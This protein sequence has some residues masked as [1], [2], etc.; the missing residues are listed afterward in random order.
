MPFLT[1]AAYKAHKEYIANGEAPGFKINYTSKEEFLLENATNVHLSYI[2]AAAYQIFPEDNTDVCH[3]CLATPKHDKQNCP[4]SISFSAQG[5]KLPI[6]CQ[7][8]YCINSSD[9]NT[10]YCPYLNRRCQECL[11]RGHH[12]DQDLCAN[13]KENQQIFLA[14]CHQGWLTKKHSDPRSSAAGFFPILTIS[15]A[16]CF[17]NMGGTQQLHTLSQEEAMS[18]LATVEGIEKSYVACEPHITESVTR[19]CLDFHAKARERREREEQD[20]RDFSRKRKAD[21]RRQ[22]TKVF[23]SRDRTPSTSSSRHASASYPPG[24]YG[25]YRKHSRKD[26]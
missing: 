17:E 16:R 20:A 3:L 18:A 10:A 24:T 1:T 14:F 25:A 7:Y 13:Y 19:E 8:P 9:H 15:A 26:N 11:F 6:I 4:L 5:G 12:A 21:P 23:W 22:T 2:T